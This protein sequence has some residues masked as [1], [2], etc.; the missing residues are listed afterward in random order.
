LGGASLIT[1]LL[2]GSQ[3]MAQPA[4]STVQE[5]VVTARQR[6]ES[7]QN[8]PAPVSVL[9]SSQLAAAG[10][11]RADNI[12]ALTPGVS[13]VN[14]T[15]EQGDV[16][17]NIRGINSARDAQNSF[18]FVLDGIQIANPSAFNRE[19]T[20]L[21]QV[22]VV[23][24]PQGAVYGRSAEAGAIIIT[25]EKPS[26]QTSGLV[27]LSGSNY[28]TYTVKGRISGTVAP[29][30]TASLS[31]D[32]RHTDGEY[33]NHQFSMHALDY[34]DGGNVNA[35][36]VWQVDAD[37]TVDLKGRYGSLKAGS[38]NFNPVFVLPALAAATSAPAF[39]EN[40][41]SHP[42]TFQ[43]NVVNDNRQDS[44][45]LSAKLDHDFG[46]AR[47]TAWG[48][49]SKIDNDLAADG[50]SASFGFFNTE[51]GCVA[52]TAAQFA[53]GVK[54]PPPQFLGPTPAQS[55]Y[56]A[57]TSTTCDGYQYQRRNQKD[58]SFEARLTSPSDQPLRWL[59]GL[60]YLHIDREVGVSTGIDSGP[61]NGVSHP[62]HELFVAA[63]QPYS[64]EQLLWDSFTSDISAVFGQVQYD[65][66]PNLEASLALRYDSED[67]SVHNLV[68]TAARTLFIDYNG[69]PFTGG[70]PLNPG[71][72]PALNPGGISDRS[73]TYSEL[74]PKIGL[75]W[76]AS[77]DW[78]IY[79]DWGVGFKSGGFNNQG[80]RTTIN[81]F[82]NPV[83]VG[84][85]FKP[86]DIQDDYKKEVSRQYELGAKGR[87]LDGK[88]FVDLSVFDNTVDNMQFFEFFVGPFGLLRV[89][90]NIDKVKLDG[91]EIG[92]Q[93]RATSELTL[94]ASYAYTHSK[95]EKNTPRPDTVGNKSPYTPDYTWNLGAQWDHELAQDYLMHARVDVRGTGPTWFHVVQNQPNPT[96]FEF[97]FGPL[98]RASFSGSQRDAYTTVDLRLGIDHKQWSLTAFGQNIFDERYLA[99]VIP[100]PEFGGIFISPAQS[101]RYGVELA[102]RF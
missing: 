60:Y 25:T 84:A 55:L 22:E 90:S 36:I 18:A 10:V 66:Q 24:G 21:Q 26:E 100:A 20:D 91:A 5:V 74:E 68:P 56:G 69:P 59:T 92:M 32:F 61:A 67:R 14:S 82:I 58:Y 93:Y 11:T 16:Q 31:G 97:S 78:T 35:R 88:L 101:A 89:V 85:G 80:S 46:W 102:Y 63:G 17:V 98:G 27:D 51:P 95:I 15:A 38:I 33:K 65:L 70:A 62:P 13:L 44:L 39:N 4:N 52:S 43:N 94:D 34:F 1:M 64:T 48:L 7:L 73:K 50:T 87:L 40:V 49:Y 45:E 19:Y 37:T 42:F 12:V 47:L 29:G 8:V 79:G 81:T 28:G 3:A 54:F 71:L 41:N 57:Y 99:E 53:A 9:T 2:V 30:V 75:R 72:D 77:P 83:R 23:K 6:A 76:S 86:V 96:V